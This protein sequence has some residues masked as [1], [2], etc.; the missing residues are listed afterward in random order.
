MP[1][2][3]LSKARGI[4]APVNQQE[5]KKKQEDE[6]GNFDY[7]LDLLGR[8]SR[9]VAGLG[10]EVIEGVRGEGF[11]PWEA[12]EGNLQL[13]EFLGGS[14]KKLNDQ[15]SKNISSVAGIDEDTWTARGLG[16]LGDTVLD[17]MNLAGGPILKA[18]KPLRRGVQKLQAASRAGQLL[19]DANAISGIV[20]PM[21]KAVADSANALRSSVSNYAG[22][23][24][25]EQAIVQLFDAKVHSLDDVVKQDLLQEVNRIDQV[26]ASIPNEAK[27][28]A[29]RGKYLAQAQA[30]AK[31]QYVQM[32]DAAKSEMARKAGPNVSPE[33]SRAMQ[34]RTENMF[35]QDATQEGLTR[36][37]N[38]P[39]I[40]QLDRGFKKSATRWNLPFY[41]NNLMGNVQQAAQEASS[42]GM[43]GYAD[44]AGEFGR[45]YGRR[46]GFNTQSNVGGLDT[47]ALE[48]LARTRGVKT[49]TSSIYKGHEV[50]GR[51]LE[52]TL[53]E[54]VSIHSHKPKKGIAAVRDPISRKLDAA[55][56][57]VE[58][59]SRQAAFN[60]YLKQELRKGIPVEEAADNAALRVTQ[61]LFDYE[62]VTP[63]MKMARSAPLMNAPFITWAAKNTPRQAAQVA[64][65]PQYFSK[66]D[67]VGRFGEGPEKDDTIP[68]Y[69][70]DRMVIPMGEI[71]GKKLMFKPAATASDLNN[72]PINMKDMSL[73]TEAIK[74][75][76]GPMATSAMEMMSN[77]DSF[78]GRNLYPD[79]SGWQE[80]LSS[81]QP[82]SNDMKWLVNQAPDAF[83]LLGDI[84]GGYLSASRNTKGDPQASYLL[85]KALGYMPTVGNAV[86]TA[87]QFAEPEKASDELP[88][89]S[90]IPFDL[91][92][93]EKMKVS[94]QFEQRNATKAVRATKKVE[95]QRRKRLSPKTMKQRMQ[96]IMDEY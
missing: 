52:D 76:A 1:N 32:L 63:L 43:R 25:E 59:G 46:L 5:V 34:T 79:G 77:K 74:G 94:Q 47:K 83:D 12:I 61:S 88:F 49:N 80:A 27:R 18:A 58:G 40:K 15:W 96:E 35:R 38:I 14:G 23:I 82:L 72:L 84:S 17:P 3:Y 4:E 73:N 7:I 91:R 85:K 81:Q 31:E 9:A 6:Q 95:Q 20:N 37:A 92:D 42:Q 21:A 90:L 24:P 89:G 69:L 56:E 50:T 53:N 45:E 19:P 66:L 48:K 86:R 64:K 60:A 13:P 26:V 55:Q 75:L 11:N 62:D 39:G 2:N 70:R 30:R 51:N 28:E 71:D 57:A 16:L 93:P 29:A 68:G 44:V 8:P 54:L 78:S 10:R 33:M 36:L 67:A 65:N 41:T 22:L 87:H